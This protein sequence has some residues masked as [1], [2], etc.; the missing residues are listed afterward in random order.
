MYKANNVLGKMSCC[1]LGKGISVF[2]GHGVAGLQL[3]F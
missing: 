1:C 2:A 3:S